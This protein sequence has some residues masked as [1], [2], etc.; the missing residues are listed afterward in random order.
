MVRKYRKLTDKYCHL[1]AGESNV[2]FRCLGEKC[3]KF[4]RFPIRKGEVGG[5]ESHEWCGCVDVL[6]FLCKIVPWVDVDIE[7]LLLMNR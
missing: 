6:L 5:A 2:P 1:H 4:V 3:V 7:T